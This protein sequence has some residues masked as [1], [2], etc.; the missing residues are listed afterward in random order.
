MILKEVIEGKVGE[1]HSILIDLGKGC[2][3]KHAKAY[4]ISREK[5]QQHAPHI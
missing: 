3:M 5:K 2:F 4:H 1:M